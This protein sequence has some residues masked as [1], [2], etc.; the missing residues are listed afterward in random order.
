MYDE[1]VPV[2]N[3]AAF[4]MAREIA[5]KE[6]ILVGISSGAAAY[7]AIELAKLPEYQGKTIA[8]I[9]PDGGDRYYSTP[10]FME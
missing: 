1:V 5:K 6:G 8:A 9:L 7:A 10:L 4:R 3:E 2:E